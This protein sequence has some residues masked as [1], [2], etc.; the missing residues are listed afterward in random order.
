MARLVVLTILVA[1][2]VAAAT[3]TNLTAF[4]ADAN[5]NFDAGAFNTV[6]GDAFPNFYFLFPNGSVINP[7]DSAST[8]IQFPMPSMLFLPPNEVVAR[9]DGG[10]SPQTLN[11]LGVN[12]F[13]DGRLTP[14]ISYLIPLG[15]NTTPPFTSGP[16][17]NGAKYTIAPDGTVVQGANALEFVAGSQ[18]IQLASSRGMF[19]LSD[20]VGPFNSTP[21]GQPDVLVWMSINVTDVPEP[22][23]SALFAFGA[24]AMY[25][26]SMSRRRG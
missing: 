15:L 3:L 10:L 24:G 9:F 23:T 26:A 6:G 14:S 4:Y 7:G 13:F 25:V 21:N 8:S 2:S 1:A 16:R 19:S 11:L 22:G 20:V 18:R 5:G 17:P 12:L